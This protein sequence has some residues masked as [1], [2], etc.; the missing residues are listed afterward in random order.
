MG[1]PQAKKAR[2]HRPQVG[3]GEEPSTVRPP[4]DPVMFARESERAIRIESTPPSA[5]PTAPPP[6]GLPEHTPG[7][8]G[9]RL[10]LGSVSSQAVPVL[11][12][13]RED[14][15]WFDLEPHVR[16]LLVH[17]DGRQSIDAIT[18][19]ACLK[20]DE[21]LEGFHE[22]AQQGIVTLQR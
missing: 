14:L 10:A 7:S 3:A 6:A 21:S 17:V 19:R 12:V 18:A 8:S 2:S 20:L 1:N 16:L 11:A 9:A 5:R 4:F 22:L 13:A 15:E